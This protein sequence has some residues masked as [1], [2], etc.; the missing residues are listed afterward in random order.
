VKLAPHHPYVADDL[1]ADHRGDVPCRCGRP[2]RNEV[3]ELPPGTAGARDRAA[4]NEMTE[5]EEEMS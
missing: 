4:S 3:H 1:P 5:E 2:A